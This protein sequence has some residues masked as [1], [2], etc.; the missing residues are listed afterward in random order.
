MAMNTVCNSLDR[1]NIL[2]SLLYFSEWPPL[3]FFFRKKTGELYY[4][5]IK[6]VELAIER[7]SAKKHRIYSLLPK[8]SGIGLLATTNH[9]R[10][11]SLKNVIFSSYIYN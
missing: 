8:Y 3:E 1:M 10:I 4:Y 9:K 6:R 5:L 2:Q 7:F 11:S